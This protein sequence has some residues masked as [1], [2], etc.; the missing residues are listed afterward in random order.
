M[1]F[2]QPGFPEIQHPTKKWWLHLHN[3]GDLPATK[4]KLT[5][6]IIIKRAEIESGVEV[7][8]INKESFVEFGRFTETLEY[9][10]LP[11]DGHVEELLLYVT[12]DFPNA[13]LKIEKLKSKERTFIDDEYSVLTYEH[14]GFNE[15]GDSDDLRKMMGIYK[16]RAD[17]KS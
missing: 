8:I 2:N 17:S 13:E 1:D 14:P 12:G 5:Y 3:N 6:S 15:L 9:D 16:G 4:V 10:Y 7:A 11:P